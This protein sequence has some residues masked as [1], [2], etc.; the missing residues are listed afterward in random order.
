MIRRIYTADTDFLQFREIDVVNP[1]G[2]ARPEGRS[3]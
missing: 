3:R 1:I 2:G